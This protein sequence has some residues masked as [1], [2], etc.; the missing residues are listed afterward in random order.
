MIPQT[1]S[2]LCT[3]QILPGGRTSVGAG[4]IPNAWAANQ[5]GQSFYFVLQQGALQ[6]LVKPTPNEIEESAF[7]F[8][9]YA[10]A[11]HP[12]IVANAS[13]PVGSMVLLFALDA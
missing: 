10:D 12:K 7:L 9:I 2:S 6:D 11:V 13:L 3:L 8:E 5:I 4:F 1:E